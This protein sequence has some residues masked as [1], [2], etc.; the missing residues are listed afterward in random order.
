MKTYRFTIRK[1]TYQVEANSIRTAKKLFRNEY[2][3]C[4]IYSITRI[5]KSGRVMNYSNSED[6]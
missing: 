5:L 6:N 3:K 2:P 4:Y 1:G